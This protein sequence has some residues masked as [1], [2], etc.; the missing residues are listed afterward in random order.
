MGRVGRCRRRRHRVAPGG[1]LL[2]VGGR[3]WRFH[4]AG[5][6][7][8]NDAGTVGGPAEPRYDPIVTP[9]RVLRLYG[10]ASDHE[11]LSWSWVDSQLRQAGTYWV[12]ARAIGHPHP[13]PVWGTWRANR[14]YLSIGS[15]AV[16][17]AVAADPRVT[18]HLDSGTDVVIVEGRVVESVADEDVLA[19]YN[20]KYDWSYEAAT[21]G[22]LLA[23]SPST[24][25][26]WRTAGWA[27]RDSFQQTGRWA[28]PPTVQELP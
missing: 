22:P 1:N 9:P 23:V 26:A 18:V 13:R 15:P 7:P 14:L 2:G 6:T 27:G 25:L 11:A 8:T 24:I 4:L 12:V 19:D 21:Y 10:E 20:Q 17:S 5:D 3:P 28:F 16:R